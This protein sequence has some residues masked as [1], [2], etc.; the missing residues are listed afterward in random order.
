MAISH[1]LDEQLSPK[2][3]LRD[4]IVTSTGVPNIPDQDY[5]VDNLKILADVLESLG[6]LIGPLVI[7]SAYRSPALQQAIIGG[8]AGAASARQAA[9]YSLHEEGMAVDLAPLTKSAQKYFADIAASPDAY[10]QLGEIAIKGNSLHIS[11]PTFTKKHYFMYVNSSDKYIHM[12]D[13]EVEAYIAAHQG[14]TASAAPVSEDEYYSEYE[15][16]GG[17]GKWI[18]LAGLAGLGLVTYF[19]M[20]KKGSRRLAAA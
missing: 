13:E 3:K 12:S 16:E 11:L 17:S 2:Y 1:S 7:L 18:L 20:K 6:S 10:M 14:E 5:L 9:T 19:M 15:E 8:A 4:L